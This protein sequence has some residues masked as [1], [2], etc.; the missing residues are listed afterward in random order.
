MRVASLLSAVVL[1][2]SC[3]RVEPH[4][5]PSMPL[6]TG[7]ESGDSGEDVVYVTTFD[8]AGTTSSQPTA[9]TGVAFI[10]GDDAHS[11]LSVDNGGGYVASG[12]F[13]LDGV[14][15]L[16]SHTSAFHELVAW[17]IDGTRGERAPQI[18][19]SGAGLKELYAHDLT[20]DGNVDLVARE[21]GLASTVLHIF[22][23]PFDL[24]TAARILR[25]TDKT[26]CMTDIDGDGFL[27]VLTYA[28]SLDVYYGPFEPGEVRE[29]QEASFDISDAHVPA[30]M[31][32]MCPGDLTGDGHNDVLVYSTMR[33]GIVPGPL[34]R[35]EGFEPSAPWLLPHRFVQG[36]D[37]VITDI[38]GNGRKAVVIRHSDDE[39]LERRLDFVLTPLSPVASELEIIQHDY[40][41][42]RNRERPWPHLDDLDGDGFLDAVVPVRMGLTPLLDQ[43]VRV[44]PGPLSE[45]AA[46][47]PIG[48]PELVIGFDGL[49]NIHPPMDVDGDGRKDIVIGVSL[50]LTGRDGVFLFT[51][52]P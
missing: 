42:W 18:W 16:V 51:L 27:D 30:V 25:P 41:F 11:W 34:L 14:V 39:T 17:D 45:L 31:R 5:D 49:P 21:L 8:S 50:A 7:A 2:G 12:D 24:S 26:P 10:D 29:A 52:E 46:D 33:Y 19:W 35:E 40:E 28:A 47:D 23:A 9:D 15:E 3:R 36:P 4:D 6:A 38:D 1:L 43:S 48:S 20:A 37:H 13:D 32:L 22:P 44:V